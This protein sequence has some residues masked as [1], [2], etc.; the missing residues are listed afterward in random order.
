MRKIVHERYGK[1]ETCVLSDNEITKL[2]DFIKKEN[3]VHI[4]TGHCTGEAGFKK[5]KEHLGD[6]VHRL[7][8]GIEF[9]L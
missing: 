4:Y 8:T 9:K 7:T 3:I 6:R 5:L 2:C 1:H